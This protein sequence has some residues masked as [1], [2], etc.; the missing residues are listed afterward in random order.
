MKDI[1][2]KLLTSDGGISRLTILDDDWHEE[3]YNKEAER[4]L[5][6]HRRWEGT[7]T[8]A[9]E[10]CFPGKTDG[11]YLGK[12]ISHEKGVLK[13]PPLRNLRNVSCVACSSMHFRINKSLAYFFADIALE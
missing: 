1:I 13:F 10:A 5:F 11:D 9:R 6:G 8:Y 4:L 2:L 12:N 7:K 3:K